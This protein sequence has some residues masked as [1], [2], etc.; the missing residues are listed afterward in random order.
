MRHGV[1]VNQVLTQALEEAVGTSSGKAN[2][3]IGTRVIDEAVKA[4]IFP[5][6]ISDGVAALLG[7]LKVGLEE[8]AAGLVV[9]LVKEEVDIVGRAAEDHGDSSFSKACAGDGFADAGTAAGDGDDSIFL[10]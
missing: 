6:D 2:T 7:I 3:V 1:V 10:S 9:Q 4:A 8:V 5:P